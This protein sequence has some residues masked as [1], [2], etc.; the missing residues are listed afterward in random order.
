MANK[1]TSAQLLIVATIAALLKE[2]KTDEEAIQDGILGY[3]ED[4]TP[5]TQDDLDLMLVEA[6]TLNAKEGEQGGASDKDT[7]GGKGGN[8]KGATKPDQKAGEKTKVKGAIEKMY[9]NK[10]KNSEYEFPKSWSDSIVIRESQF[11]KV[12]NTER[13]IVEIPSSVKLKPFD[14]SLFDV[15]VK[16]KMFVGKKV[17]I[18]HDPR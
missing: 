14:A 7:K 9:G 1:L 16:N 11:T 2:G 5:L 17:Q 13:D 15:H 4:E 12:G 8:G 10:D 3:P 6:K 18:L